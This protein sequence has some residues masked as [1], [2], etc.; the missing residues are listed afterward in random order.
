[1]IVRI[2]IC[3]ILIIIGHK[4]VAQDRP[5]GTQEPAQSARKASHYIGIQAN[6]LLRQLISFGGSSAVNNPYLLTY[7]ANSKSDG[8]G[9]ATGLG[10]SSVTTRSTDN[11]TSVVS[12]VNDFA[13]RL[14]LEK[15]KYLSKYWLAGFGGDVVIDAN[16]AETISHS[17]N[18][19]DIS[20]TSK[21]KRAG[22]GPRASLA[23][24]FHD[25]LMVGTEAAYYFRWGNQEQTTNNSGQPNDNTKVKS[26]AFSLPSAIFL[27]M[28]L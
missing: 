21:T 3:L 11:F 1:M 4:L 16:T 13:W 20:V 17:D 12:K 6:Q 19:P 23:F 25:R 28:K 15:K 10:F 24:Q 8:F 9:F 18:T 14:G 22:F 2:L 27:T 26:F 7:S 5:A